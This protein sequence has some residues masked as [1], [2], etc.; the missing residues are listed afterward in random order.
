MTNFCPNQKL[1]RQSND[2]LSDCLLHPL[3]VKIFSEEEPEMTGFSMLQGAEFMMYNVDLRPAR[4]VLRV[5]LFR[6]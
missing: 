1:L 6:F 3:T 2:C 5:T 4:T